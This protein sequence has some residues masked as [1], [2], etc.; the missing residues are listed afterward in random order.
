[1]F[2]PVSPPPPERS[3]HVTEDAHNALAARVNELE[4]EVRNLKMMVQGLGFSGLKDINEKSPAEIIESGF[5]PAHTMSFTP[6][7]ASPPA[8]HTHTDPQATV[9]TGATQEET[10]Q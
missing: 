6:S 5:S 2:N 8:T 4:A 7:P 1:M 10:E 9:I 3:G